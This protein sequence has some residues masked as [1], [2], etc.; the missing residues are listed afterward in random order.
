MRHGPFFGRPPPPLIAAPI[1]FKTRPNGFKR[2]RTT[3]EFSGASRGWTVPLALKRLAVRRPD[4]ATTSSGSTC[5]S[6]P[7][8]KEI[9]SGNVHL[10]IHP[11]YWKSAPSDAGDGTKV[12]CGVG[13]FASGPRG[14]RTD[15]PSGP[16]HQKKRR[17]W[18]QP[19]M[20]PSKQRW[21]PRM[22]W[23]QSPQTSGCRFRCAKG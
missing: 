19:K 2:A 1:S 11:A 4:P 12:K 23:F 6:K 15:R 5:G 10:A 13:N 17:L 16:G 3:L 14:P 8:S 7:S 22:T 18:T 9:R 21:R 20:P